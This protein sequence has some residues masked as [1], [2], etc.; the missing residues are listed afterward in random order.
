MEFNAPKKTRAIRFLQ[1]KAKAGEIASIYQLYRNYSEGRDVQSDSKLASS[2]FSQL[3]S[4]LGSKRFI[5]KSIHLNNF[6]RFKEIVVEFDRRLTVIIGDN[7]SGKTSIV[8]AIAKLFSWFNNNLEKDDVNGRPVVESDVNLSAS[9]AEVAGFFGVGSQNIFDSKLCKSAPGVSGGAKSDVV[10]LKLYASIYKAVEK[11]PAIIIPLLVYYSVDR[12]GFSISN[13]FPDNL[14]DNLRDSRFN[15]LDESTSGKAGFKG[16]FE[17]YISLFDRSHS[18]EDSEIEKLKSEIKSIQ[19]IIDS[20][21]QTE[22]LSVLEILQ[23]QLLLK[24]QELADRQNTPKQGYEKHLQFVNKAIYSLV[25]DVSNLHVDRTSGK[26]V[27]FV[28]NFGNKVSVSQLSKGQQTLLVMAGDLARRLVTLNPGTDNPLDGFGIA[29]I[30]EIDLHLHPRWQQEVLPALLRTFP[31]MQ[32]IVTTHSPQ[33]LSTVD[34]KSIRKLVFDSENNPLIVVPGFQ[35]KGVAS[36]DV[37]CRI[38]DINPIP[39]NLDEAIWQRKFSEAL[40]SGDDES[41]SQYFKLILQHF[42]EEHPV[43]EECRSQER[44]FNIRKSLKKPL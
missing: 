30:D 36:A 25:P 41:K 12:S 34:N 29:L 7:G 15:A 42:G 39:E 4:A 6:R 37:L 16:F 40:E 17:Y 44:I 18:A 20:L 33:V 23:N 8:D 2:Y 13:T 9:E 11:S 3:Q 32:F 31:N 19:S 1:E 28:N 24:S 27:I 10:L 38:M 14:E 43:V 26:T 22:N 21:K 35:T 5:L